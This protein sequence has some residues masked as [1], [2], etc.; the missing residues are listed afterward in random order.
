MKIIGKIKSNKGHGKE[1]FLTQITLQEMRVLRNL[2]TFKG[3]YP[4]PDGSK[5]YNV[6][7]ELR[8]FMFKSFIKDKNIK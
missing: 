4:Y 8:R 6:L 2:I 3:K 1:D 7:S 5:N